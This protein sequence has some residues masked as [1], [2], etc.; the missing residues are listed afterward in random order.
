MTENTIRR[1]ENRAKAMDW[2]GEGCV[3]CGSLENLEFDHI[4]ANR[5]DTKHCISQ[6]LDKSWSKIFKELIKCQLLCKDCHWDKTRKDRNL[7][8]KVHGTVNMYING[9]CRCLLCR[10]AWTVYFA[11]R[12]FKSQGKTLYRG[13]N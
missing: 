5:K 4:E 6:M 8:S 9:K 7:F 13:T 10:K 3:V 11:P 2:F 12:K 1:A